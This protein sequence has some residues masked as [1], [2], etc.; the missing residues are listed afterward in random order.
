M[1]SGLNDTL[2]EY[3]TVTGTSAGIAPVPDPTGTSALF[4]WTFT[5]TFELW[6]DSSCRVAGRLDHSGESDPD[7]FVRF[8]ILHGNPNPEK[9]SAYVK[10][11]CVEAQ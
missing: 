11:R 10:I 6:C 4:T 5:H 9:N 1:G 3:T 8:K 7:I 2:D